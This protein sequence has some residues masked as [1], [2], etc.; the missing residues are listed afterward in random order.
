MARCYFKMKYLHTKTIIPAV[1]VT[2]IE[3]AALLF[4]V[5]SLVLL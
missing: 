3:V 2:D 4:W 1:T 5:F